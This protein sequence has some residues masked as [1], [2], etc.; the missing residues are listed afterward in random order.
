MPRRKRAV[1]VTSD[2]DEHSSNPNTPKKG[3]IQAAFAK[4]SSKATQNG[5]PSPLKPMQHIPQTRRSTKTASPRK[6]SQPASQSNS[7]AGKKAKD[8]KIYSFF[9]SV[10]QKQSSRRS[11]SPEKASAQSLEV[12]DDNIQD[13][14]DED[15]KTQLDV[16]PVFNPG[17]KRKSESLDDGFVSSNPRGSQKFLR[18]LPT[19]NGSSSATSIAVPQEL[20]PWTDQ[21]S[22]VDLEELAVHKKKVQDVSDWISKVTAGKDRK[23]LLVLKGGAGAGKTTT[24]Q[25]LAQKLGLKLTEWRNP[26]TAGRAEGQASI[27]A[28]FEDFISRTSIFGALQFGSETKSDRNET[29]EPHRIILVEEFPNTF[30]RSSSTLQSF[31]NA[32]LHYLAAATPS[33]DSMF[34]R[35]TGPQPPV[36]PVI[37]IISESLLSTSTAAA[38][39]FTAHRLLGPEILNH[40]GT[41][42]IEFNP[43][44]PTFMS[45]AL[46]LVL[47]KEAKT[48]GRKFIPG[49]AVLKHLSETG[50]VRSAISALEFFCLHQGDANDWSGKIQTL[51]P[52]KKPIDPAITTM[53]KQTLE[54]ITQR[55]S[56]LGIFHSVGKVVY[57]KREVPP[58]MDTPPPQPPSWFPQ[59]ARNKISEVDVDS[60][61]NE[62]GTDV[63][64]FI[65]ALHENYVLSC[66]G[67]TDEDTLDTVNGCIDCLSDSDLISPERYASNHSRYAFQGTTADRLRQD[68]MSFDTSVRG[69]L[70]NLPHPV[71]R[72]VPPLEYSNGR[73]KG[74]NKSTANQMLYPTSLRLWRKKEQIDELVSLVNEKFRNG[75]FEAS[76][77][78]QQNVS[79]PGSV[80]T[81]KRHANFSGAI[82]QYSKASHDED[83][84]DSLLVRGAGKNELLLERL[85]YLSQ[86]ERKKPSFKRSAL[87]KQLDRVTAFAGLTSIL[88]NAEEDDAE[89]EDDVPEQW[90]TDKP[91]DDRA[92]VWKKSVGI[93]STAADGNVVVKKS[94]ES[95]V[96]EDDD[97]QD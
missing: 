17:T 64:V 32:V 74:A 81:W 4:A 50:D 91:V 15:R 30:S 11:T 59:H 6:Q 68:E 38:D 92:D 40:A 90:S 49:P 93:V 56:T 97:I 2:E 24:V 3:S 63:H 20:R 28:Q 85:P 72:V 76:L 58:T 78:G 25:L 12:E 43:I 16:K 62:L 83:T 8:N 33:I 65:A 1:V 77:N 57:N 61:L 46:D 7:P 10:T 22:P 96:L 37:L 48:S 42:A 44:A 79:K 84:G 5:S 14:S 54:M 21:Y 71:K 23:R 53:E 73:G 47:K 26:D 69:I 82:D 55:E 60:L 35:K 75:Q 45:K 36:V 88:T 66:S 52:K 67:M 31:R 34:A 95:L 18:T 89:P 19:A 94:M 86:L 87:S 9:N 80:D 51:K 29:A 13:E 27:A 70:F 39:S 41:T